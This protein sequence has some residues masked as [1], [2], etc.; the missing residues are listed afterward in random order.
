MG[1]DFIEGA[2]LSRA[3]FYRGRDLFEG[4]NYFKVEGQDAQTI[5]S[6]VFARIYSR[7]QTIRSIRVIKMGRKLKEIDICETCGKSPEDFP[8]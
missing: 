8:S 5:G 4:V 7:A 3:R 2:V 6:K 1:R